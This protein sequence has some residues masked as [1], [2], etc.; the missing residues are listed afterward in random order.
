MTD[1]SA[2]DVSAFLSRLRVEREPPSADALVRLHRAVL[3]RV[4]YETTWIHL[5]ER[6]GVDRLASLRRIAYR[7]R[8]GYCFQINGAFSLL[9]E[10]L[11]YD[12]TLHVGGVHRADGPTVEAMTNHLVLQ[13]HGLP[14]DGCP[15]GSWYVDAGL[16]DALHEPLPLVAG[17]YRQGPFEFGLAISDASFADWQF[18]HH[19]SGSF[20][21][22]VFR[23]EPAAIGEFDDRHE[24]LSTSPDSVFV[25]TLTVQRRDATGVD[26]IRGQVL[27][28][29]ESSVV[30]ERTLVSESEWFEA[31]AD[32]F[33][34]PL[35]DV[36]AA[37]RHVLWTRVHG[38]HQAWLAAQD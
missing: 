26:V 32:G 29:V 27:Q 4:P 24:F 13:V 18:Q 33:D 6:W 15:D 22:M 34:L 16:G 5:G 25:Q 38:A 17:T 19:P 35:A 2:A 30:S 36:S 37:D 3:E 28:R 11:G 9:L 20:A 31:L 12:V 7:Q 1:L 23:S 14:A 8:G 21:G 10:A